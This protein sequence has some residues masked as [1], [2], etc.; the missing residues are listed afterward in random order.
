VSRQLV[1]ELQRVA[2]RASNI[3]HGTDFTFL[4]DQRRKLLRVGY[5]VDSGE[6]DPY[7]YGLLASEARTAAFLAIAKHDIPREAWFHLGRKLTSYQDAS[8]LLSWS[9]TM[10][11]YAM[12]A[13]FMKSYEGTLLGS[14]LRRA[15]RIQQLYA[16]ERRIPWGISEAAYSGADGGHERRYQAFGVPVLAI[17]RMRPSDLVVA[18][19]ATLLAL[20]IDRAAAIDNLRT[21]AQKRWIGRYGFF[22]SID[23]RSRGPG[24]AAQPRIV[25]VFMAHHQG[26][27]LMALDNAMFDA[28]MQKRFHSEPLV[29]AAELLLQE[30][31]PKLV[32]AAEP[33]MTG[34]LAA[35]HLQPSIEPPDREI[36]PASEGVAMSAS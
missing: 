1:I 19:Y 30:R 20:M 4:F 12:P 25:P 33:Q 8:T 28:A 26:M 31:L 6:L 17:K 14:S 24:G 7:C 2:A 13:L 35:V 21:M 15:V 27:S 22:E 29:L 11:E 9:G 32:T 10:F 3:A 18:P 23:Y 5:T 36:A 34:G 16:R